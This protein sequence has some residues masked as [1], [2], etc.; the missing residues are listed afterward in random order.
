M[1]SIGSVAILIAFALSACAPLPGGVRFTGKY[2][3][4]TVV[5]QPK[6]YPAP[7]K[8]EVKTGNQGCTQGAGAKLGCVRFGANEIGTITFALFQQQAGDQCAPAGTADWVITKIELSAS[9]DAATEKGVFGGAQPAWLTAAFPGANSDNGVVYSATK[10]MGTTTV[11]V[12][13]ENDHDARE[14]VKLAYYQ[15][16]AM[17]CTSGQAVDIDPMV[18]NTG[19]E[20]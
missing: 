7:G 19:R 8:L 17:N 12:F 9:G 18:E 10:D 4:Y 14:G 11:A 20:R 6:A 3:P 16:T 13:D 15:V 2:Q 5:L 1:K